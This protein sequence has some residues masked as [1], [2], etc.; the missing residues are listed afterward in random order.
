MSAGIE[1]DYVKPDDSRVYAHTKVVGGGESTTIE[2]THSF[3]RSL[4]IGRL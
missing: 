1:N 2:I 4:D 3:V